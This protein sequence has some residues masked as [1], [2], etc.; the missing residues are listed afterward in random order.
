MINLVNKIIYLFLN[1]IRS[2]IIK[3]QKIKLI[4]MMHIKNI[5]IS[6][7]TYQVKEILMT[8]Y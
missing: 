8:F 5:Q 1:G 2:Y 4:F 7:M 3:L 6:I